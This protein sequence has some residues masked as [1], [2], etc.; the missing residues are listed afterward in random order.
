MAGAVYLMHMCGGEVN[1]WYE[2]KNDQFQRSMITS[3]VH[4][5]IVP[6]CILSDCVCACACKQSF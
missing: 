5:A 3:F 1:V 2:N 6:L 4:F